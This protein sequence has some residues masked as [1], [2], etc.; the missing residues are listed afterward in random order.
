[1]MQLLQ[2]SPD[3][4][5]DT[6]QEFLSRLKPG[7][8]VPELF[9][10]I[11]GAYYFVKDRN[12]R[13]MAG[14]RS[15][16][17]SFGEESMATVIGRS[18]YD[19]SPDSLADAF[20]ADDKL[21]ME[22][23]QPI[24][25]RIEL[26][27]TRDGSLDWLST[28]KIPLYDDFGQIIGLAGVSRIIRDS[29]SVYADNPEMYR[30]VNFVRTHYRDKL[31][32]ADMAREGGISVSSQERLFRK[33]FGLTPMMYL[34]KTRLNAAC[35]MLRETEASMAEIADQCGFSDQTNMTRAFRIEL[36]ITPLKYRRRFSDSTS[37]RARN[38]NTFHQRH[39]LQRP[40]DHN[41][42]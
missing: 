21:V 9:D 30:I 7:Q 5:P 26:V 17:R 15:F 6:R 22:T 31:T 33:V 27:P 20:Y 2:R 29:E 25:N 36:K 39:V 42:H 38:G 11:P 37:G 12:C 34:R 35:R 23:G 16:A 3:I 19:F 13:F 14:S 10:T 24:L 8:L 40:G 1:M 28:S 32:V 18:D 4:S 41:E